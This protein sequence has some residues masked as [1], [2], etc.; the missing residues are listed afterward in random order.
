MDLEIESDKPAEKL[1]FLEW[2]IQM[3]ENEKQRIQEDN[4]LSDKEKRQKLSDRTD[5]L[6]NFQEKR[7]ALRNSTKKK[8]TVQK[9]FSV[10]SNVN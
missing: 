4:S 7:N 10:F 6:K 5:A 9:K 1:K 8:S 2:K 3:I